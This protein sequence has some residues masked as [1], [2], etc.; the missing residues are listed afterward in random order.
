M[1]GNGEPGLKESRAWSGGGRCEETKG[2]GWCPIRYLFSRSWPKPDRSGPWVNP[3]PIS[4]QPFGC[5]YHH[6]EDTP[7]VRTGRRLHPLGPSQSCRAASGSVVAG[8]RAA[9][10]GS[11]E[12][13]GRKVAET[14][15]AVG[16]DEGERKEERWE[17]LRIYSREPEA[18]MPQAAR[19]QSI[20]LQ[21]PSQSPEATRPQLRHSLERG[22]RQETG[23]S[24]A[25][26]QAW[27]QQ[28][29]TR[30]IGSVERTAPEEHGIRCAGWGE[31]GY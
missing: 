8:G 30:V 2:K 4:L 27:A 6:F 22:W 7:G 12:V 19:N 16:V 17:K 21:A 26:N 5:E 13:V 31:N 29:Q 10:S 11:V 28:R 3:E 23:P 1:W 9:S 15:V 14:F 24:V 20:C 18:V 25:A